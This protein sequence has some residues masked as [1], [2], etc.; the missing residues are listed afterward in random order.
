MARTTSTST[1]VRSM[2]AVEILIRPSVCETSGDA[3]SVQFT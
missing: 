3:L 1:P 2:I